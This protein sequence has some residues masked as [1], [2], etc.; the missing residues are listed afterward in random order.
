MPGRVPGGCLQS[1]AETI[2]TVW[3]LLQQLPDPTTQQPAQPVPSPWTQGRGHPKTA[4]LSLEG[5][6]WALPALPLPIPAPGSPL[7]ALPSGKW[8]QPGADAR[9]AALGVRGWQARLPAPPRGLTGLYG[10]S[11]WPCV[12]GCKGGPPLPDSLCPQPGGPL[13]GG[14][15]GPQ[16]NHL[17]EGL[18]VLDARARVGP[19]SAEQSPCPLRG[20]ALP[21]VRQTTLTLPVQGP[22]GAGRPSSQTVSLSS[23]QHVQGARPRLCPV[24]WARGAVRVT[25][26]AGPCSEVPPRS[27]AT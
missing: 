18:R 25:N 22:V 17:G 10:A 16:R 19:G 3:C 1:P 14:V 21:R 6:A 20:Q 9:P 11:A 5:P 26:R 12:A 8:M 4:R 23:S 15:W 24:Q 27:V 7:P 2:V 13:Q